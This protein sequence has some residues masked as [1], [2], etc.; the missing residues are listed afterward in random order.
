MFSMM[1]GKWILILG[2]MKDFWILHCTVITTSLL[3]KYISMSLTKKEEETSWGRQCKVRA[4]VSAMC[5]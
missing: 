3:E 1:E 2:T 4:L 5:S